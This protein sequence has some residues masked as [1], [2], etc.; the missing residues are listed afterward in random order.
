MANKN[1]RV[2]G[3]VHT[4]ESTTLNHA[5]QAMPPAIAELAGTLSRGLGAQFRTKAPSPTLSEQQIRHLAAFRPSQVEMP[6]NLAASVIDLACVICNK[7][8]LR[9]IGVGLQLVWNLEDPAND[10]VMAHCGVN[11][12]IRS[13]MEAQMAKT[14]IAEQV[15]AEAA[16]SGS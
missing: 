1:P 2:N 9:A 15:K 7:P 16:G 6:L 11:L 5:R 3:K 12:S 13:L 4:P 14:A 8:I 10:V